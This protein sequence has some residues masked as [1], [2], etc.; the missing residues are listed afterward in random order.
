MQDKLTRKQLIY[1][2]RKLFLTSGRKQWAGKN[3][4]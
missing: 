2:K 1:A 4:L 3:I